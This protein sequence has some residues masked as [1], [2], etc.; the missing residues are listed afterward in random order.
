MSRKPLTEEQLKERRKEILDAAMI[1]FESAENDST[2]GGLSEVSFRKIAALLGCSYTMIYS[3]F[4]NKA[5]LVNAMRAR[6]FWWI[7][8]EMQHSIDPRQDHESQL[9]SLTNAYIKAGIEKPQRYALMYF[10][11][12]HSDASEHNLEL[13]RAKRES[14]NVCVEVLAAGQKAGAF[15]KEINPLAAGHLFWI[16]AH[17]IVSLQVAGQL[18]MGQDLTTLQPML[19]AVLRS[20]LGLPAAS[21]DNASPL[22]FSTEHPPKATTQPTEGSQSIATHQ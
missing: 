17:G 5:A 6:A 16:G 15:P 7:Q 12:D 8:K 9:H 13:H 2:A 11:V 18:V 20:G 3:Y 4:P 21:E 10:D 22:I 14:L 1:L 19:V